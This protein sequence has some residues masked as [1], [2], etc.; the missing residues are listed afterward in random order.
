V[1]IAILW[2]L[3]AGA[4]YAGFGAA[5]PFERALALYNRTDY[6]AA[7]A[8]LRESPGSDEKSAG[9]LKL[10]GQCYFML[11]KFKDSTDA[12]EKAA[13]LEP[14]DS[15]LLTWLGRAWGRRAETS[16][17]LTAIGYA[18]KTREGF[19]RAVQIDPGNPEALGDLFDFYMGAPRFMGGGTDKAA[20]LLAQ[21]E[22]YDPVGAYEA[23]A[24]ISETKQRFAAAETDLRRAIE[25]APKSVS[26]VLNLAQFLAR[27]GRY[28]ESENVFRQA[29]MVAPESPRIPFAKADTYLK[30]GRNIEQAREL[31]K[32]YIAAKNLTPGDPP[33][34]EA[35]KLLKKAEG[36]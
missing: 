35:Q 9:N 13:A 25:A 33:R 20:A 36:N 29:A 31:L 28:E 3:I 32:K 26:L 1:R 19:E 12:L 27:R 5:A 30:T 24:R 8:M 21:Y 4:A 11:G 7:I 16:F 10:L 23:R 17:P 15:M 14:N 22:R 2:S 18:T 34:W 6:T